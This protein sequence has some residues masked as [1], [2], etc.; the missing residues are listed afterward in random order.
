MAHFSKK[1]TINYDRITKSIGQDY[2]FFRLSCPKFYQNCCCLSSVI[3]SSVTPSCWN[4]I[5]P[6]RHYTSHCYI[7]RLY[8][9][10]TCSNMFTYHQFSRNSWTGPWSSALSTL[11]PSCTLPAAYKPSPPRSVS[12]S[13]SWRLC[14]KT[15]QLQARA[16]AGSE[17]DPLSSTHCSRPQRGKI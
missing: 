15:G 2:L 6:L 1:N 12:W 17:G 9:L 5:H 8:P 13:Q 14:P 7:I 11:L 3:L 4:Q 10:I 16:S